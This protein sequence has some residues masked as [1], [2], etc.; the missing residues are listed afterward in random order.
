MSNLRAKIQDGFSSLNFHIN[1]T[2][3]EAR[4]F[5]E[6]WVKSNNYQLLLYCIFI[7]YR[8]QYSNIGWHNHL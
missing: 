7:V 6:M 3:H 2:I 4:E 8:E 1:L 5:T